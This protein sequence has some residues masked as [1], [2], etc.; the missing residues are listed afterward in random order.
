MDTLTHAL[1]GALLARATAPAISRPGE[2]TPRTRMAAGFLAAAFPDSDIVLRVFGA[3]PYLDL[4]RGVTHSIIMLPAW[5]LVL[6]WL[7]SRF[8]RQCYSWRAIYGTAA[9]GIAIHIAGDVFTAYG[10]MVLA[11]FSYHR[12]ALPFT[13]IIDPY[14]TAIIV[15]G[16]AAAMLRRQ[17]RYPA[18][19]A[20]VVLGGYVGF[21]GVLHSQVIK[22]GKAYAAAHRLEGT[23][24]GIHAIPQP[25]SPFNWKIIV[26]HGDNYYEALV[27][28]RHIQ[29]LK[30]PDTANGISAIWGRI[31]SGYQPPSMA[32][33]RHYGR[34]GEIE[35]QDALAREAWSQEIFTRYRQFAMFPFLDRIES[36]GSGVCV[37]FLDLRFTLPSLPPSLGFGVC[38]DSAGDP[39]RLGQKAGA[40]GTDTISELLGMEGD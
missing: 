40:F 16:L 20:L 39:W 11:P 21:Q 18:I 26:I 3:L 9:L 6:A 13:F 37:W 8:S 33:W 19:I 23:G 10:T 35:S 32:T 22:V 7:F 29:V 28:L 36:T 12:F 5:A 30:P 38:R 27:N 25:L 17:G 2:L 1:S 14:F 34:F 15:M 4:H 31:A 24:T